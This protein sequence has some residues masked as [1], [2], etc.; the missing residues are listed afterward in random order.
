MRLCVCGVRP[1]QLGSY[2][3]TFV[4]PPFASILLDLRQGAQGLILLLLRAFVRML[5]FGYTGAWVR[6]EGKQSFLPPF[7]ASP[8]SVPFVVPPLLLLFFSEKRVYLWN[9]C[10]DHWLPNMPGTPEVSMVRPL[11]QGLTANTPRFPLVST[12]PGRSIVLHVLAPL[13]RVKAPPLLAALPPREH[14]YAA[15]SFAADGAEAPGLFSAWAAHTAPLA[16]P[17]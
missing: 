12:V 1:T 7:D 8:V 9:C 6:G 3:R 10:C 14:L 5:L 17:I 11:F 13:T 15:V 16:P 4:R 2:G